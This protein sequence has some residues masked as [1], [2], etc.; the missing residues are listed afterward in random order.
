MNNKRTSIWGK[1]QKKKL[2]YTDYFSMR[3]K[4]SRTKKHKPLYFS[5]EIAR[6]YNPKNMY[7]SYRMFFYNSE[8]ILFETIFNPID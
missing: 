2:H 8:I 5:G 3:K 1:I 6:M 4:K 7:N